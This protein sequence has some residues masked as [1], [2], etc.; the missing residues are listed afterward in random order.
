MEP[1]ELN[2]EKEIDIFLSE[3]NTMSK[4]EAKTEI[5]RLLNKVKGNNGP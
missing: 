2:I 1:E 4:S 3:Y 5:L